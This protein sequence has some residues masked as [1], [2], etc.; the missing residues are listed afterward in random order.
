MIDEAKIVLPP[1]HE[2]VAVVN[3]PPFLQIRGDL[4]KRGPTFDYKNSLPCAPV[5]WRN[6]IVAEGEC[7]EHQYD[8]AE[9]YT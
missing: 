5:L 9:G 6:G 8:K 3:D 1:K 2:K 4:P 7:Q